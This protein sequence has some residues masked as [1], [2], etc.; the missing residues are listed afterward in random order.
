MDD[1]SL[2]FNE[3]SDFM[4]K[5]IEFFDDDMKRENYRVV[6]L[7]VKQNYPI[8]R[9]LMEWHL[10]DGD[11]LQLVHADAPGYVWDGC[12]DSEGK[13]Y[14]GDSICINKDLKLIYHYREESF[15]DQLRRVLKKWR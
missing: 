9:H 11:Y 4:N 5:R 12:S 14:T 7:D 8:R 3:L 1:A 6:I 15:F 2:A 10:Q 13:E